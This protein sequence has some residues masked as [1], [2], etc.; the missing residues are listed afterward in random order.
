MQ[1]KV[2]E[3]LARILH[4]GGPTPCS[5]F[6]SERRIFRGKY[7]RGSE[8][9]PLQAF[10]LIE[11]LV[12]IAIIAILAAMLLPALSKAKERARI[13]NC[14]SNEH[15]LSLATLMYANDNQEKLP[16]CQNLGVWVW[17]VSAYVITNLQQS[18]VRQDIFYC[19]NE[20]YLYNSSTPNAWQ[21]FTQSRTPPYPYIVTGYIWMFPNSRADAVLTSFT[22]VVKTT[23]PRPG[24]GIATTEIIADATIF[25]NSMGG[26]QYDN[27]SAAGGTTVRSAHLNGPR[28]TG[29]NTTF[30]DGHIE[31]RTF[32]Q[33]TNLAN[34]MGGGLG[35]MF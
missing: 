25:L 5:G 28:P 7:R 13:A 1:R 30:L 31:W 20:H 29:G 6:S 19:P 34:P 27:I 17:D 23:T 14:K 4:D 33:M 18:A 24:C 2:E 3:G 26:R 10:T 21:A 22:N 9:T 16:D 32:N 12:V 8:E 11:L 35:F 15:Q